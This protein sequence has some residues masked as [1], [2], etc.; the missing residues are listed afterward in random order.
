MLQVQIDIWLAGLESDEDMFFGTFLNTKRFNSNDSKLI[1]EALSK[2]MK[3]TSCDSLYVS[4]LKH[5][6]LLPKSTFERL[7]TMM[8]IDKVVQQL[9]LQRAGENQDPLVAITNLD[10]LTLLNNLDNH[11]HLKEVEAKSV[12][13]NEKIKKLE[14]EI[15]HLKKNGHGI[16]KGNLQAMQEKFE[17]HSRN[18]S[19][20]PQES[21]AKNPRIKNFGKFI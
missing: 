20:Y 15:D 21:A 2:S 17:S 13:A 5:L 11:D 9:V 12:V 1:S 19:N 14:L 18:A 10:M 3:D 7:K 4:I 6:A 8:V 16:V